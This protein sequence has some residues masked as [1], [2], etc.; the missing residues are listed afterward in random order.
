MNRLSIL[1]LIP[2]NTVGIDMLKKKLDFYPVLD[3]L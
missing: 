3:S 1:L 2:F